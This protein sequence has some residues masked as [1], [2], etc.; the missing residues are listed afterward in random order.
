MAALVRGALAMH[1]LTSTLQDIKT[2]VFIMD[3]QTAASSITLTTQHLTQF[4][5]I[6]IR[7]HANTLLYSSPDCHI[8]IIWT[9][10]HCGI[11]GNECADRLARLT[12][13]LLSFLHS[14]I[15]W[16]HDNARASVFRA[17][18]HEWAAKLHTNLT[19][20]H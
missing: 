11:K 9:P 1:E 7:D 15:I 4:M 14:T 2:I 20:M 17:W 3:S 12:V 13:S 6:I 10:G 8:E 19:S 5:L 16:M 18:Q